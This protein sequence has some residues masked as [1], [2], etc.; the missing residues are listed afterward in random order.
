[1]RLS[2]REDIVRMISE[3]SGTSGYATRI[4]RSRRK[5][6]RARRLPLRFI[7]NR[8]A[9]SLSSFSLALSPSPSPSLLHVILFRGPL[10]PRRSDRELGGAGHF[11]VT[12]VL[13]RAPISISHFGLPPSR[14]TSSSGT[15][16]NEKEH[17]A[18]SPIPSVQ[19]HSAKRT[20]V[21]ECLDT[22]R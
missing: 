10:T 19:R 9:R 3:T 21:A 2:D 15:R 12:S 18:R 7:Y 16:R 20:R 11:K 14:F 13:M 6:S 17:P 22:R 5:R 4:A 1:M 8:R